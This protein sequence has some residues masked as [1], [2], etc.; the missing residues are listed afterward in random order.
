MI[1]YKKAEE[2]LKAG[3]A[4]KQAVKYAH[5]VYDENSHSATS[6]EEKEVTVIDA[7]DMPALFAAIR[8]VSPA[9]HKVPDRP[10]HLRGYEPHGEDRAGQKTRFAP[11]CQSG[12]GAVTG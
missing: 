4:R 8:P 12:V 11:R 1:R 10:I 6:T 7:A 3:K 9:S 5:N 2:Y